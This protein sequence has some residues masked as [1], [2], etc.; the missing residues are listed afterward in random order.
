ML[1][2]GL[3]LAAVLVPVQIA[4]G[5]LN[6]DYLVRKQPSKIAAIEGRWEDEQPAGEVMFAWPDVKAERNLFEVRLPA[7]FGSLIDSIQPS[8]PGDRHQVDP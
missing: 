3:G 6:G 2:M 7:P 1:R 5:H 4:F 8:L